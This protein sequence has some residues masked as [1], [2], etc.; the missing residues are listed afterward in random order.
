MPKEYRTIQEVAG[1][2]MLVRGVEDVA[3]DELGEIE[4]ANGERR[5]CKVLEIDKDVIPLLPLA[6]IVSGT[7]ASFA[8]FGEESGWRGYMMPKLFQ[9][10][11][12]VPALIAGGIIW[13]LW[14]APL[15]CIGH[16][17]GTD[18]PGFPYTGI[19]R[20]CVFCVF[21]GIILT[22]VTERSGSIWPAAILHAVN[23]TNPGILNA[24]LNFD[25]LTEAGGI[26]ASFTGRM[27]PMVV[28]AAGFLFFSQRGGFKADE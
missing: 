13:G 7:I 6:M 23:N 18:Y 15:T 26:A 14:H 17:F 21:M 24:Y 9:L 5:R 12:R 8:A 19:V 11:G 4:L 20:M 10:M 16:N 1:P 25:R 22:F 28:I 2:L 3:Y 27:L